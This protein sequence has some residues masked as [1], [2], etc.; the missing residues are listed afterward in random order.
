[1]K[2]NKIV[3]SSLIPGLCMFLICALSSL[4]A[5]SQTPSSYF[6]EPGFSLGFESSEKWSHSFALSNRTL[7]TQRLDGEEISGAENEHIDLDHYTKYKTSASTAVSLGIRYRFRELFNDEKYDEL[8]FIQQLD[9]SH[10]E[11]ALD[12]GHR[13]RAEQRLKNIVTEH[14]FR[15]RFGGS[16]D[17]N[18]VFALGLAT[19]ALLSI[20]REAK[21]SLEQ[22]FILELANTSFEDLEI[23][24][25][26]DYEMADYNNELEHE[27]FLLTGV[28]LKL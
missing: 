2:R 10:P 23:S 16:K 20:A 28:A 27:F 22:R 6:F 11:S 8:R 4:S 14:R 9:I 7:L 24:L 12:L 17:L 15:Y 26:L 18:E 3:S 1:M 25:A 19:E 5:R 21:P 13:F